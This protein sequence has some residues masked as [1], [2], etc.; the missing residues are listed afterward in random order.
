MGTVTAAAY[1]RE[2]FGRWTV[3][4]LGFV[5]LAFSFT[6]RGSL[7]LAM[8]N[9]QAEFDW[10]RSSISGIAATAML[11]MAAVAPFAGNIADRKGPKGLLTFGLAAIGFGMILVIL[12]GPGSRSWLLPLG[13]AGI[14][15]FGFGSIAQHVVAAAIAQRF[16][17]N[18]GL[19]TGVGTAGSTGGQLMLMPVLAAMMQ[20]GDWR[21]AFV[22][23]AVGCFLL[24]PFT[25]VLLRA[26]VDAV[27]GSAEN[28][29]GE[30]APF[31]QSFVTLAKSP[32]FHAIFWSYTVCGFTT[33]GVIETHLMPYASFCGFGPVPSATAYGVLSGLNLVGMIAAGWLSDRMH[34][35]LLLAVIYFVRAGTFV[36]LGFIGDSYPL[37]ILFSVLFGLFD[38]STVPVTASY[39]ASR[40]GVRVLGLSMGLLSAGHAVGGAAGAWAGGLIFDWNQAYGIVWLV[41]AL[42]S[43]GAA[44]LVVSLKDGKELDTRGRPDPHISERTVP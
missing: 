38:Y 30:S 27:G 2:N 21:S 17:R 26:P 22:L 10:S 34:R 9:W 24:I 42:S 12:A 39:V 6:V 18:R 1:S 19:A 33:S 41:S 36:L 16:D 3:V 15:A 43:L 28:H 31:G 40:M 7:S 23:L 8:P 32:V 13:F 11:V 25:L 29:G 20:G 4:I 14:A 44:A 37:L 35:P 5:T